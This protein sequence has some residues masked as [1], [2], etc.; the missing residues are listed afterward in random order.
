MG[1]LEDQKA[2]RRAR[3]LASARR[4]IAER[5][6]DGLT[7]RELAAASRVSVPTLYNL[8]GGKHALLVGELEET[9]TR[10]DAS[11]R[12]ARGDGFAERMVAG[13]E[14]ANDDLLSVPRYSRA[15][16]HLTLTSPETEGMRRDI[17]QRYVA[18]MADVLRKGQAAGEIA[19]FV[20]AEAVAARAYAHYIATMIQWAVGDLDDAEFRAA[21]VLGPC[22]M[23][24]GIARG[25]AARGLEGRVRELQKALA[26]SHARTRRRRDA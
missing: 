15:L 14:A 24:L 5:G 10:V 21:T 3:I 22:L 4:L 9:F 11:M 13:C 20:D 25:A 23:L 18:S 1:L 8:F 2:E 7:M 19:D 6:F 26:R 16:I 12:A 17:N